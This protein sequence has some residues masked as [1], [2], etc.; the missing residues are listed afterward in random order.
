[1]RGFG[2]S[3]MRA[4]MDGVDYESRGTTVRLRK[5]RPPA[6]ADDREEE[7]EEA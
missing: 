6:Y 3:I 4:V 1:V 2:I 7:S 5:R